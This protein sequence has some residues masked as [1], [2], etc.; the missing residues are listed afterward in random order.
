MDS[1]VPLLDALIAL[2]ATLYAFAFIVAMAV[3]MLQRVARMREERLRAILDAF[4][5]KTLKPIAKEKLLAT[6]S[7]PKRVQSGLDAL[8]PQ[9]LVTAVA[10]AR[11]ANPKATLAKLDWN[12]LVAQARQYE[13]WQQLEKEAGERWSVIELQFKQGFE[14]ATVQASHFLGERLR[15]IALA[16][17]VLFA[18]AFN[19]SA[20]RLYEFY[21]SNPEI[22]A[23][24]VEKLETWYETAAEKSSEVS[25]LG[26]SCDETAQD[27]AACL[28]ALRQEAGNLVALTES[29]PEILPQEIPIGWTA[30]QQEAWMCWA[31]AEKPACESSTLLAFLRWFVSVFVTGLI[32]GAGAPH[33]HDLLQMLL[34]LRGKKIEV[35]PPAALGST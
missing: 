15:A 4:I 11:P 1:V 6:M 5:E 8:E 21:S 24:A 30:T 10:G 7:D 23:A 31:A 32:I 28:A 12:G 33:L 35:P 34:S 26:T 17:G 27:D 14:N 25:T 22:A 29:L 13:W 20:L 18:F 2:V 3:E 9:Q 16:L 19:V